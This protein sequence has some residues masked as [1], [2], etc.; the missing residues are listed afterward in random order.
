M[1]FELFDQLVQLIYSKSM[2]KSL[3]WNYIFADTSFCLISG[4]PVWSRD[5]PDPSAGVRQGQHQDGQEQAG[6][7]SQPPTLPA[8][9]WATVH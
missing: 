5:P 9:P 7:H 8:E 3:L 1:I 6:W 2:D 4:G